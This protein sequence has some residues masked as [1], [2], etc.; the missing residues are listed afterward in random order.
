MRGVFPDFPQHAGGIRRLA[1]GLARSPAADPQYGG[2][3]A[4]ARVILA[5][6]IGQWA[7]L[8]QFVKMHQ[9]KAVG[10]K[11]NVLDQPGLLRFAQ[12]IPVH[13]VEDVFVGRVIAGGVVEKIP[14]VALGDFQ[15][16]L[17]LVGAFIPEQRVGG[18]GCAIV[19]RGNDGEQGF[20]EVAVDQQIHAPAPFAEAR[21]EVTLLDLPA[22]EV[23][24]RREF[25]GE[26]IRVRLGN[27][28]LGGPGPVLL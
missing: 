3:A 23:Q 8:A 19:L 17:R 20:R 2:V 28:Y 6:E 5:P 16:E 15:F 14:P 18:R 21:V 27:R 1:H 9:V 12:E 13:E 7:P 25:D 22:L 11:F 24:E 10:L 4:F 26:G